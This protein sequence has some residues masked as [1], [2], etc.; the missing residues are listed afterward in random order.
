MI[1]ARRDYNLRHPK[2]V[3]GSA[4]RK[5]TLHPTLGITRIGSEMLF[6]QE[7]AVMANGQ[8]FLE[9][10]FVDFLDEA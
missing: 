7:D 6:F 4:S 8:D 3:E 9:L 1:P 2:F 10:V 5:W